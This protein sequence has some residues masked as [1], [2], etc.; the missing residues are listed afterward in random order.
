MILFSSV[1]LGRWFNLRI[2][3]IFWFFRCF[4][5]RQ[6]LLCRLILLVIHIPNST[7]ILSGSK[8]RRRVHLGPLQEHILVGNDGGVILNKNCFRVVVH[9]VVG[10]IRLFP[11]RVS[12]HTTLNS[13][14]FIETK[15]RSCIISW[16]RRRMVWAKCPFSLSAG[17]LHY[18][19][20]IHCRIL[21]PKSSECQDSNLITGR[22]FRLQWKS[23]ALGLIVFGVV[24]GDDV[25]W[26]D[27]VDRK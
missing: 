18:T 22:L 12:H 25:L 27:F 21:T 6:H 20:S 19:V 13:I 15:L 2:N 17:C 1:K 4:H 7:T 14:Y 23:N 3:G 26:I 24:H 9:K 16:E 10:W 11:S 5:T 8:S